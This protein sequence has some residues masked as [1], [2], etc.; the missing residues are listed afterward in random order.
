MSEPVW[1][2]LGAVGLPKAVFPIDFRNPMTAAFAGNA[3]P[4]ISAL[5]GWEAWSWAFSP[6]TEGWI[7]GVFRLPENAPSGAASLKFDFHSASAGPVVIAATLKGI[8][9][10]ESLNISAWDFAPA[11]VTVTLAVRTRKV[12]VVSGITI[13]THIAPGDLGVVAL[14]RKP[15]DAGDTNAGA[16]EL[17]SGALVVA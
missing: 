16:L 7:F 9:D 13:P 3:Y 17:L 1:V 10:G 4:A 5:T 12:Q 2:P 6:T 8:S 11:N 15:A 14:G